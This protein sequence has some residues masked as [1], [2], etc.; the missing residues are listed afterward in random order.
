MQF[1][2]PVFCA[3]AVFYLCCMPTL[4]FYCFA[5]DN[6]LESDLKYGKEYKMYFIF[7]FILTI[8]RD[9]HV[10][11]SI[12]VFLSIIVLLSEELPL[13]ADLVVQVCYYKFS[14]LLFVI[15]KRYFWWIWNYRL[16]LF[17]FGTLRGHTSFA[18]LFCAGS[19]QSGSELNRI[20]VCC[21]F[22]YLQCS[23]SFKFFWCLHVLFSGLHTF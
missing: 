3:L 20:W 23:T 4:H 16:T 17:P 19:S 2:P 13:L 18:R 9:L 21:C 6:Y 22:D 11:T 8:S 1:F 7:A 14:R 5:L 15:F 12:H 10:F